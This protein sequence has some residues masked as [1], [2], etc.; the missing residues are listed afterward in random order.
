MK[1]AKARALVHRFCNATHDMAFLGT[2]P[3]FSDDP[4]EQLA[5]NAER[6]RIHTN[7]TRAENALIKALTEGENAE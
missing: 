1:L 2:I 5:I 4:D 3:L 6:R 7:F